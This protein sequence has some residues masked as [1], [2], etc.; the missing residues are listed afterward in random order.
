M[1]DFEYFAPSTLEEALR[2][3]DEKKESAR[4]LAGGTDLIVQMKSGRV[5]PSSIIDIKKVPELNRLEWDAAIGL[6]VGAAVPISRMNA[7]PPVAS[8]Y[9]LLYDACSLIGS[10]Q[11]RNRATMGGNICNAAPSADSAPPLLCLE[12]RAVAASMNGTRTIP[13]TDFFVGPGINTLA[14][15]ELLVGIEIPPPPG[16]AA[17]SYLRHIPRQD[18]DIAVVG[19]ASFLV[20]SPENGLCTEARIA[21]GAVAPT[22]IRAPLAES[23]LVGTDLANDALEEAAHLASESARPI[24]DMR[25]SEGYRKELVRVLT[26]RTLAKAMSLITDRRQG[27]G[28]L[29]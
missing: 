13:M 28:Q 2:L 1:K 27:Q 4:L 22:P 25:G 16:Q 14:P 17:G 12:A 6:F 18:M 19:V 7:F 20:V 5:G 11:L 8:E 9:G 3:L 15:N 23:V 24:S 21:L 26:K 10:F 29:K